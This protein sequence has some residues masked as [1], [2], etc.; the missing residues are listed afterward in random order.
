MTS[1]KLASAKAELRS[2]HSMK[3]NMP[4]WLFQRIDVI[5]KSRC[6]IRGLVKIRSVISHILVRA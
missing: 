5:E 4:L 2:I 6:M 3:N 1:N